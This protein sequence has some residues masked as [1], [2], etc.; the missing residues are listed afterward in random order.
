MKNLSI[1]LILFLGILLG[2]SQLQG[3]VGN[4]NPTGPTGDF[5]GEITTGGSY[6]PYTGNAKR[7]ITDIDVAGAMGKYGLSYSR[8]WNSRGHRW[9]GSYE[10][11]IDSLDFVP[12]TQTVLNYTVRFPDGRVYTFT[13]TTGG[14]IVG[15]AAGMKERFKPINAGLPRLGYLILPDGG[16]I[17]FLCTRTTN[18]DPEL[19]PSTWYTYDFDVQ[20]IIDPY[21]QRT[22]Y[23][24]NADGTTTITEPAG[25]W[26]KLYSDH[27]VASDGRSVYYKT[28]TQTFPP[29][30][31]PYGVTTQVLYYGNATSAPYTANYTYQ[32]PNVGD[33]NG[34][35][36]LKTADD[37]MYPG[38]MK[39]IGY[40]YKTGTNADGTAAVYGQIFSENY[41]DGVNPNTLGAAVTSLSVNGTTR[42]ETRADGK[43]RTFAYD[44]VTALSSSATD[45]K[46]V[47]Q[48]LL[49]YTGFV[50]EITDRNGHATDFT[51]T[52]AGALT[53]IQYPATPGDA[54]AGRGTVNYAYGW[55]SCP[56]P[57]NRDATN[58]YYLYSVTDEGG[59]TTIFTRDTSKR[60]TRIDYPDGGNE[61]F[62]YN[63]FGQILTHV[64]TTG[65]T[66]S[67]TYDASGSR[68]TY[69]NPSNATGNPTARYSYDSFNRVSAVT[70][71]LGTSN[72][73]LNH[74]TSFDYNARGQLT[75]TTFPIDPIDTL[76]H[77]IIN[78]Y[79]SDGTLAS[80]TDQLGHITSFTYDDYRR[81][82]TTT[83]PQRA[84]GDNT[85]RT[86]YAYY[87]ASGTGNDYTHTD[88]NVT[89]GTL[90]GGEKTTTT[91]DENLRK[92]S[93]TVADG[94]ADSAKTSF[95]YDNAGN[96]TSVVSPKE[97]SGQPYAGQ[98]TV[99][100]YD[101][102]NRMASVTD[103]LGKV[104][105][106]TYDAAG[107]K[108]SVTRPNGQVTTYDTF[109]AMNRLLQQTVKQTPDP[110]AV[111]KYTYYTSGLLHTMQDPQ[112]VAIGSSYSYSYAYDNMGRKTSVT[113]PPAV[114]G[115]SATSESYAYDNA[116]H[117]QTFTNRG[118]NI[119]TFTYDALNRTTGFSW[120]DSGLT[121][122]VTFGYDVASRTTSI[123]N[124]PNATITRS[125]LND[126]LL[127]SET[128]TYADSTARTV[129]YSYDADARRATI[130]YPNG[131]YSFTY[132]YTGRNQL[133]TLVNNSGG[134][135][136]I[137]YGYDPDGNLST[138]SPD[139]L[140]S[141]S[142]TYDALD[143]VTHISHALSGI[144]APTFDYDYDAVGNRKWTK[145]NSANGDVFGYD[146]NDQVTAIKLDIA[147]PDTTS[148]GSQTINCDANG[149]RTT[150][151]AYGPTDTYTTN[152]LNQYTAR[153]LSTATYDAK[154][155][156]TTGLDGS[157]YTYDS[158][159]RLLTATKGGSTETFNYDGLNRQVSRTIGAG[160]PTYNVYDGWELIGEYA[161][162]ATSAS[163]AYLSGAGGLVKNL[164]TNR[165]YYQDASGSTSHL[166]SNSGALLEWYRYDLHG[167]PI[168]YDASN[169][170]I[171]PSVRH[172]F[173]GQQWYSEIGLYDLRN[174]FYSPDVGRFLQSDPIKFKGDA[175]NLYRYCRNNPVKWRDPSGLQSQSDTGHK[176]Y[177][178][179]VGEADNG[180][181][182]NTVI[183]Y[184]NAIPT[185]ENSGYCNK[186]LSAGDSTSGS[187]GSLGADGGNG[188]HF[189]SNGNKLPPPTPT[190]A[191]TPTPT[192][193]PTPTPDPCSEC[194]QQWA[195]CLAEGPT[196]QN[197]QSGTGETT[198]SN[199]F[200]SLQKLQS[201]HDAYRDCMS[202]NGCR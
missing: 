50:R 148:I 19:R 160:S 6:D 127:S 51:N 96:L 163:T 71:V 39:R 128:T 16:K 175:T 22:T 62:T 202:Q 11:S 23:T 106:C 124:P 14:A 158:Q 44:S 191:P 58:P 121:P 189:D 57:N 66:E 38:P 194:E 31:V 43:T 93:V 155:N 82:L 48:S 166:A 199:I 142:Y 25:R 103:P 104:T 83:T 129:T 132:N 85:A 183:V 27:I 59:H 107:H 171:T 91:Y 17:E 174:R 69:R 100:A 182:D 54:P 4:N 78:A 20:A 94:T 143:R 122:S 60:V 157:T 87:D 188:D 135:T 167:T 197:D 2:A 181:S 173:T 26:I 73:D 34:V 115:G 36:L 198:L 7:T 52:I 116:G 170:P 150:F 92:T 29:G 81:L 185:A 178:S 110:D 10:W 145:R 165:Y 190:P 64:L 84:A 45:F 46:G 130:Q 9:S 120:N 131:A 12:T 152:N 123:T 176:P 74:T 41:Y 15:G 101:E 193:T 147:N 201:C 102:R 161:S 28:Q 112:L 154:G 137:T 169:N 97:Q 108:A 35:P 95:S 24:Y 184:G 109:D 114:N 40:V 105:S 140:T 164:T 179:P 61:T 113:Y 49:Y 86:T 80:K 76:R 75:T 146:L 141:S 138:R 67:F 21:G 53:Q 90:P 111:T 159:N 18:S 125:Y 119:Q 151:A 156:V 55:G 180:H 186:D 162:G 37:P 117:L 72:T 118:G 133:K 56:D 136:L 149:N 42:T 134:G 200:A 168:G 5:N 126:N 8:T 98:S 88:A 3:Q 192:A 89:H 65:D 68:L 1:S 30:I 77:T 70:D 99:T 153:N 47:A 79:N 63:S 13:G 177:Q 196:L 172:L 33:V 139:N 187:G 32:G 144:T 195:E